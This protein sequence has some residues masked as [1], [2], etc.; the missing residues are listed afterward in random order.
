M[1]WSFLFDVLQSRGYQIKQEWR[2]PSLHTRSTSICI[3]FV[4]YSKWLSRKEIK[5]NDCGKKNK[6]TRKNIKMIKTVSS[7]W[8]KGDRRYKCSN[9]MPTDHVCRQSTIYEASKN[10]SSNEQ[11]KHFPNWNVWDRCISWNISD[12]ISKQNETLIETCGTYTT[13]VIA[14]QLFGSRYP[15]VL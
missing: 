3:P 13:H 5:T 8:E 1:H 14:A 2:Q 12:K 11:T 10:D 9:L 6:N 15:H 4:I 7:L